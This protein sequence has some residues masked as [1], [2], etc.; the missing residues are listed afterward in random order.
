MTREEKVALAVPRRDPEVMDIDRMKRQGVC[1]N[2]GTKGHIA[3]RCPEPRKERK[4][5]R[6]RVGLEKEVD[7]MLTDEMREFIRS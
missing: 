4:Y 1:F 6:R 7:E 3:A 5:F 2:C